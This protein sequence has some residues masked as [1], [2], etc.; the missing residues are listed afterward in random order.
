MNKLKIFWIIT[1]LFTML[2]VSFWY[3]ED[4]VYCNF[5]K[6]RVLLTMKDSEWKV[7]CKTYLD[8][9]YNKSREKYKE[10]SLIRWYISQWEDLF[11]RKPL[12]EKREDEFLKLVS[13]REQIKS[14]I[15]KFESDFFVKYYALLENPMK[16]YYSD[17]EMQYYALINEKQSHGS[18]EYWIKIADIEQQMRN[19]SHILNAKTLDDIIEVIPTYIYQKSRISW[20]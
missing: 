4:K 20:K 10:I 2:W 8:A 5:E 12:L 15:N 6:D 18:A 7:R 3:F 19:V 14:A 16:M 1:I 11:Y 13:Y 9:I 17:L